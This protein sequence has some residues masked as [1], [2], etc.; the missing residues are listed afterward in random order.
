MVKK[1]LEVLI[2]LIWINISSR[3]GRIE[4]DVIHIIK[5]RWLKVEKCS[6]CFT[7]S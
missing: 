5:A 7:W 2:F 6:S 1:Y 3:W 4:E